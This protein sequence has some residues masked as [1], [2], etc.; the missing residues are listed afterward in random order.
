MFGD[1]QF[2]KI[3]AFSPFSTTGVV[4]LDDTTELTVP[5]FFCSGNYGEKDY[6]KGYSLAKSVKRQSFKIALGAIPT[7]VDLM[8]K[9]IQINGAYW[10]IDEVRGNQS[11]ILDLS[12][13]PGKAPAPVVEPESPTDPTPEPTPVEEETP[14]TEETPDENNEEE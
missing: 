7:G 10:I 6:D 9:K 1:S 2:E 11:G 8:R 12:L 13:K 14:N 4:V 5:G 3:L